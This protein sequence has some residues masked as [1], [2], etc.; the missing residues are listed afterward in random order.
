MAC[1]SGPEIS[2]NSLIFQYDD[3]NTTKSWIGR[4]T[5]NLIN[6][7][8]SGISRYNNPGFSGAAVNTGKTY[9]GCPIWELTF[10]AQNSTFISRLSSTEGFGAINYLP[11][12]QANTRYLASIYVK[13]DFPLQNSAS[14]GFV[15][16]YANIAG[17]GQNSTTSSRYEDDGWTR[18]YTQYYNNTNGY[19]ARTNYPT[20]SFTV[21][22][23]ATQTIDLM[24]TIPANGA[25]IGDFNTLYAF[26]SA[27]PSIAN[28]GG[29]TGLSIVNHGLD[30]TNFTKL[31]WPSSIKL[32][33][34]LPFNYYVRVSVPSTGGVNKTISLY[35]NLGS[36]HT[37]V[38]D[39]KF[40]KITF[41]TTN[42]AVGQVIKT[43]WCCPMIEQH[44]TAYPSIFTIDNRPA[45]QAI[46]DLTGNTTLTA[47]NLTYDINGEFGFDG[48]SSKLT[49]DVIPVM[50]NTNF[51][52][53][54]V[55]T[56]TSL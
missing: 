27:S 10:I 46:K 45:T 22:T 23:T 31:S 41:D 28:N 34:D 14:N 11:S 21:N 49:A 53:E 6:P 5:S 15:N 50:S 35:A 40:W 3:K 36:Y 20:Y 29:L 30:T 55:F 4:P 7:I 52:C 13:T 54:C 43:Y 25:G 42:L 33:T 17:W 37:A 47:S 38:T 24:Y 32:K 26:V 18:L 8:T 16:T 19:A 44:D 1:Y 56:T 9:K 2:N 39:S 51:S 48:V 12:L